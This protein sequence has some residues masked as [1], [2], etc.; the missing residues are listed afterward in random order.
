MLHMAG[1]VPVQGRAPLV[2]HGHGPGTFCQDLSD[3]CRD[4]SVMAR[5][6]GR[7]SAFVKPAGVRV[8]AAPGKPSRPHARACAG[9]ERQHERVLDGEG[10]LVEQPSDARVDCS[11]RERQDG[12]RRMNRCARTCSRNRV[13][14]TLRSA[15]QREP[16]AVYACALRRRLTVAVTRALKRALCEGASVYWLRPP[17]CSSARRSS[18]AFRDSP[19]SLKTRVSSVHDSL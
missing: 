8:R 6:V 4:L 2:S 19:S 13:V 16:R 7:V 9:S 1:L 11:C 3:T 14:A 12:M 15:R 10:S 18:N 17:I 5:Q